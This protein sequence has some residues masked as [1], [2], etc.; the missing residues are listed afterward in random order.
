MEWSSQITYERKVI[1]MDEHGI[2][3]PCVKC[4]SIRKLL[5]DGVNDGS[6]YLVGLTEDKKKV[7][8]DRQKTCNCR[9]NRDEKKMS[10]KRVARKV[11][12]RL[13]V[14]KLSSSKMNYFPNKSKGRN[15]P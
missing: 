2:D 9:M 15:N 14:R 6:I 3:C 5:R 7:M 1:E 12:D 4:E 10:R 13:W 11:K 8:E